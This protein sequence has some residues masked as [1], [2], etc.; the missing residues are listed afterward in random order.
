MSTYHDFRRRSLKRRARQKII[1]STFL[2]LAVFILGGVTWYAGSSIGLFSFL[3]TSDEQSASSSIGLEEEFKGEDV[4]IE[5]IATATPQPVIITN[6]TSIATPN[7][8]DANWNTVDYGIRVLST[9]IKTEDDG[10]TAMDFRLAG[11]EEN[12]VIDL[13][14]FDTV[15]FLGDS[16]T[17]GFEIYDTD[18]VGVGAE[19]CAYK[20]IGP[21]AVVNLSTVTDV[22]GTQEIALDA[23]VASE[24]EQVYILLGTNTLVSNSDYSSFLAYYGMIIDMIYERLPDVTI[25]VQSITPVRPNVVSTTPGL[26]TSRLMEINDALAALAL[27]KDCYFVNLW[28]ALADENG[29]LIE[30]YDAGDGIHLNATGYRAWLSYLRTHTAYTPEASYEAGTSYKIED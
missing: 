28:E 27:S 26:Y 14:Y 7:E 17:Q 2:S 12:G 1:A 21:Q 8:E 24:P 6:Q 22:F 23:I 30:S 29:D 5:P 13:S 16:I 18:I 10:T 25:Y 20:S 15:T 11:L 19:F 3:E 4:V 9:E